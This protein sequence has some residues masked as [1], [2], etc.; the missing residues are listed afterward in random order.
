MCFSAYPDMHVCAGRACIFII[1][2]AVCIYTHMYV[3]LFLF[4]HQSVDVYL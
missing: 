4:R 1:F 3:I 2:N